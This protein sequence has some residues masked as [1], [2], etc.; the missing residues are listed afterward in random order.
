MAIDDAA[1]PFDAATD[2]PAGPEVRP[3][4]GDAAPPE[5]DRVPWLGLL[6]GDDVY[7]LPLDRLREVAPLTRVRRVP[8]APAG[9]A[10]LVNLRGEIVCALDARTILGLTA[11]APSSGRFLVALRGF[12]DPLA[13]I[14][15]AITDIYAIDPGDMRAAPGDPGAGRTSFM[16][17]TAETREGTIGLLDL[18]RVVGV[19]S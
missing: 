12:R 15:D 2:I 11:P 4:G 16:I 3:G 1:T 7:G 17:G 13:L 14:V 8:G 9:V 6:V 5:P 18:N 10:G 19:T